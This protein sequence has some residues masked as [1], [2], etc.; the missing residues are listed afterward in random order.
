VGNSKFQKLAGMEHLSAILWKQTLK[1]A[2]NLVRLA[3][4]Y[5]EERELSLAL[6]CLLP[7]YRAIA[8]RSVIRDALSRNSS[9][10]IVFV[11]RH[12]LSFGP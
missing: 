8:E 1:Y 6:R 3:K 5:K 10:H 12:S 11:V 4:V 9:T 7:P 2:F